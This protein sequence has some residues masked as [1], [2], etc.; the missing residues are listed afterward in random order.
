MSRPLTCCV[1]ALVSCLTFV[2]PAPN[3]QPAQRAGR[4]LTIEDY[5]RV[6]SIGN[7][8]I[9]PN[10]QWVAFTVTT[11]LEEPDANSSR[12][13][14]WVVP[15]DAS[16]EPRRVQHQGK[17]VVNPSWADD[18]S[19][20]YTVDG[21]RWTIDP[22]NVAATAQQVQGTAGRSG[23]GGGRGAGRGGGRGELA[24]A[25]A[26]G[27]WEAVTVSTPQRNVSPTYANEFEK[28]HQ[29]RFKGAIF[30][31]KDFQR[32]GAEFPVPNPTAQPAQ[33]IAVRPRS[34]ERSNIQGP[35]ARTSELP[36]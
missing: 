27:K 36:S 9:S 21:E 25:S 11:R 35:M 7:H 10:S 22:T 12:S 28:R 29:E 17:D 20:E 31:W 19:L 4:A 18:G 6:Q 26:D 30:D 3:A 23:R 1:V 34:T 5:Y 13:E 24:V 16:A 33:Q 32:D 8:S 15:A 14:T 2:A